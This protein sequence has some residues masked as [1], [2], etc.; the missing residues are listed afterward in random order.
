M[1]INILFMLDVFLSDDYR[2][3][4]EEVGVYRTLAVRDLPA[5]V[6]M[7]VPSESWDAVINVGCTMQVCAGFLLS[8]DP[9][10]MAHKA[11]V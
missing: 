10:V 9:S 2:T 8:T 4:P 6:D 3:N 7:V 5:L 1:R 11:C